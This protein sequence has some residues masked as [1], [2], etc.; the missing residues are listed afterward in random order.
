VN[1]WCKKSIVNKIAK[2]SLTHLSKQ[3]KKK[4]GSVKKKIQMQILFALSFLMYPPM[5]FLNREKRRNECTCLPQ[6]PVK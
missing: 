4:K 1:N 3:G 2:H 5:V 6:K